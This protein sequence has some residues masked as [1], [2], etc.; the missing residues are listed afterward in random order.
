[1]A[2]SG[3]DGDERC[4]WRAVPVAASGADGGERGWCRWQVELLMVMELLMT[5]ETTDGATN[6]AANDQIKKEHSG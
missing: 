3:T 1:M 6:R 4:R 5:I 2:A